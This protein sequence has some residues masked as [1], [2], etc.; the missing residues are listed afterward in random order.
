MAKGISEI[1]GEASG[2][3]GVRATFYRALKVFICSGC[4]ETINEGRFAP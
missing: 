1:A 2:A 4:S 3:G